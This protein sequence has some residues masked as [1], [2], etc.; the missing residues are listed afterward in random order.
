MV[1]YR[2]CVWVLLLA[3]VVVSYSTPLHSTERSKILTTSTANYNYL[4]S[5][6]RLHDFVG[7]VVRLLGSRA[8][9]EHVNNT[10]GL[11]RMKWLAHVYCVTLS[12]L[13]YVCWQTF[14]GLDG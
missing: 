6:L 9:D 2:S 7:I 8:D 11:W 5:I 12:V 4:C 1:N 3:T 14:I 10:G 13:V